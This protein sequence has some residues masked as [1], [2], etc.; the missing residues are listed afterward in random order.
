MTNQNYIIGL[1]LV[2]DGEAVVAAMANPR[3]EEHDVPSIM[4][5]VKDK[6][7]RYWPASGSGPIPAKLTPALQEKKVLWVVK[8]ESLA[9]FRGPTRSLHRPL[10]PHLLVY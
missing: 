10:Q 7:L 6:G 8:M 9:K 5:A 3:L 2:V 4:V 1:A